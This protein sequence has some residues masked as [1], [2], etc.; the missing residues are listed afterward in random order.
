M[1]TVGSEVAA[2]PNAGLDAAITLAAMVVSIVV[3]AVLVSINA[4]DIQKLRATRVLATLVPASGTLLGQNADALQSSEWVP[5]EDPKQV[6]VLFGIAESGQTGGMEFW[7]EVVARSHQATPSIRFVGLCLARSAC[8]QQNDDHFTLLRLMDP[9]QT[10][11][12]AVA[13]RRG[14]AF[15]YRGKQPEG[16]LPI[17][18]DQQAFVLELTR[19]V[20]RNGRGSGA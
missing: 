5:S 13:S 14:Q 6:V 18:A 8:S 15:I 3:L 11:A 10:H 19:I 1:N 4:I 16:T 2:R 12:L 17:R 20:N 7:R 9:L